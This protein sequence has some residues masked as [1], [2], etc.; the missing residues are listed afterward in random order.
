MFLYNLSVILT[1]QP[2]HRALHA[3][4]VFFT[5]M[6]KLFPVFIDNLLVKHR[7]LPKVIFVP[8]LQ[9]CTSYPWLLSSATKCVPPHLCPG[10]R[11]AVLQLGRDSL[12]SADTELLDEIKA[13]FLPLFSSRF[14]T[15]TPHSIWYKVCFSLCSDGDTLNPPTAIKNTSWV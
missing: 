4:N 6:V 13:M 2:I 11:R 12:S 10:K 8:Q 3:F 14:F 7:S 1:V 5:W 15:F 9:P